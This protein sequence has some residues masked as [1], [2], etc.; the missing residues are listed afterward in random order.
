M[1]SK[2]TG[3][4]SAQKL[5]IVVA[6]NVCSL[7]V[8]SALTG[9]WSAG[10]DAGV[11]KPGFKFNLITT[12]VGAGLFGSISAGIALMIDEEI[13]RRALEE[14]DECLQSLEGQELDLNNFQLDQNQVY[15]NPGYQSQVYQNPGY[16]NPIQEVPYE[17]QGYPNPSAQ[18]FVAEEPEYSSP[19][20]T[21]EA[22]VQPEQVQ[23]AQ[24]KQEPND[25]RLLV[26]SW[27]VQPVDDQDPWGAM[28]QP[29]STPAETTTGSP[30]ST[31]D[32]L[33]PD[34]LKSKSTYLDGL[35][36]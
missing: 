15:Q 13:M 5:V 28:E 26:P 2:K 23:P 21:P 8:F 6:T 30:K 3:R 18:F 12:I 14:A 1:R 9:L 25:S 27:K 33:I 7:I 16:Q 36:L 32:T 31:P 35:G 29:P 10:V 34:T 19:S 11:I 24:T 4:S 22:F 17:A 20:Q